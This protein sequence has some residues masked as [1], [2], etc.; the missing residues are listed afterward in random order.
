MKRFGFFV[1]LLIA[2]SF[3]LAGCGG[4]S[5]SNTTTSLDNPQTIEIDNIT[6]Y[7]E[8]QTNPAPT[9]ED[10]SDAGVEGITSDNL[11]EMNAL[12]ATLTASDVDTL[13][14][15]QAILD[16]AGLRI[17]DQ[18]DSSTTT[19]LDNPQTIEID[20]I[21]AYA[22]DQTNPAP[23]VEDYSD[24]GVEGITSDN[25]DEM[26]ALVATL[27]ASDVDTLEEIQ[28]ILDEA[29]LG[30]VDQS[31]TTAPVITLLGT[32]QVTV[33]QGDTYT[34]AGATALDNIDGDI[35][36][37]IVTVNPI[38]T[39][40]VG[41]YTITYSATDSAGNSATE[42]RTVYVNAP[43]PEVTYELQEGNHALMGP[44]KDATVSIFS[45]SD[46]QNPV[47]VMQTGEVG[48]FTVSLDGIPDDEL[49]LVSVSG[50]EDIDVD[51]DGRLDNTS[52]LNSGTIHTY[53]KASALKAN[54]VN[55]TL[56]SEIIYQYT[57]HYI[58]NVHPDDLEKVIERVAAKFY[59][60]TSDKNINSFIPIDIN[61]RNELNFE[62]LSFVNGDDPLVSLYHSDFN[63]TKIEEKL[64]HLFA[65][66]AL[67]FRDIGL[68]ENASYTQVTLEEPLN[69]SIAS[70]GT[71]IFSNANDQTKQLTD[72]V[73]QG[74]KMTFTVSLD[75]KMKILSWN[76]CDSV[77]SD[78]LV[79]TLKAS[80]THHSVTPNVVYKENIYADNVKELTDYAVT[81]DTNNYNVTLEL[82]A[83]SESKDYVAAIIVDDIIVSMNPDNPFFA[84]VTNATQIDAYHYIFE[85]EEMS[86]L[87]LYKQG[88]IFTNRS[89]THE[90]LVSAAS[91]LNRS[92]LY[93]SKDGMRL[94]PPTHESDDE[95]VIVFEGT[96][97]L[98]RNLG[99]TSKEINLPIAEGVTVKGSM[100]F[101]LTPEFNMNME[102]FSLESLRFVVVK[103][104]KTSLSIKYSKDWTEKLDPKEFLK[105][106]LAT[107][108]YWIPNTPI[109]LNIHLDFSLLVDYNIESLISVGGEYT[110]T[111]TVG[112]NYVNEDL[113]VIDSELSDGDFLGEM[114]PLTL[115]A[116]Q[117]VKLSP[118]VTINSIAGVE[119]ETKTG[120]YEEIAPLADGDLFK[121]KVDAKFSAG[122]KW[123]WSDLLAKYD[124][125]KD[126]GDKIN[127]GIKKATGGLEY[128][129]SYNLYEWSNECDEKTEDTVDGQ[130]IAKSCPMIYDPLLDDDTNTFSLTVLTPDQKLHCTFYDSG[131]LASEF[132][133]YVY[134]IRSGTVK[135]YYESGILREETT[136]VDDI[137]HGI[138]KY[139]YTSGIL[140]E[141]T[142][143]VDGIRN[144]IYK[145]YY[146]SGEIYIETPFVDGI[147][148]GIKK[149]YY[150]SGILREEI[151]YVDGH[152]SGIRKY[153]YESE[154]L[155]WETPYVDGI[156]NGIE[157]YYRESGTL[158][159]ET[160]YVD[161]IINGIYKLYYDSGA[162]SREIP[163][164]DGIINGIYKL[165]NESGT[166]YSETPF[167]DGIVNGI[168]KRYRES[169]AISRETPYVDGLKNGIEKIYYESGAISRET[170]YVDEI[171]NGIEKIYYESGNIRV[172]SIYS[173]GDYVSKCT[174]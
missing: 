124:W 118:V 151:P 9:V 76:G 138:Q 94:L 161:G 87:D 145:K 112:F 163:Y 1:N 153:Y 137:R 12:V 108:N 33:T 97:T 70:T 115:T 64:N 15:I 90:D 117:Y 38:D 47:E 56:L 55:V 139:Y 32:T 24:A 147:A 17:A 52:T 46:L 75:D 78:L 37:N 74:T 81:I 61:S 86:I 13:E 53:A 152:K 51:D 42:T 54:I 71:D 143:Y 3:F 169:G 36:A 29:R 63:L 166:L 114:K 44:L 34:E 164:V 21:T 66:R 134:M 159:S 135:H 26:N 154:V 40:T 158:Y 120:L 28:A 91:S 83:S 73:L 60:A 35:T 121:G 170:T 162:I 16:E 140:N 31:D 45:L 101:K 92:L 106:K 111:N 23:T 43:E 146:S 155:K 130:C 102:W 89:L 84:R 48:A 6:A 85:T 80:A 173:N 149:S 14:E 58:G 8:D 98:N 5:T 129:Y 22:E 141:E 160:P 104:I 172:C 125:A 30:I 100:S 65:G 156:I 171:R 107:W 59:T 119:L 133:Y 99:E 105:Q 128:V 68:L 50:G 62:Y 67:S 132:P 113:S 77:S 41:T 144:G 49:L 69:T 88:S 2:S 57:R 27:T 126:L 167:V 10:Y 25:L 148:N 7:A 116:G 109:V 95:F 122:L 82:N 4:S 96:D 165:Y 72:F 11:D 93:Q 127:K 131:A 79:C 18:S 103:E 150:K 20:N 110:K 123:V 168:E 157:K 136:Y 174:P 142:T 39:D 19:S